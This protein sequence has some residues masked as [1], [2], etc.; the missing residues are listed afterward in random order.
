MHLLPVAA[1]AVAFM[2]APAANADEVIG[3]I[4]A[5]IESTPTVWQTQL[6]EGDDVSRGTNYR[7]FGFVWQVSLLGRPPEDAGDEGDRLVIGFSGID[8][9]IEATEAMIVLFKADGGRSY[10]S[11]EAGDGLVQ[12]SRLE[13]KKGKAFAEGLFAATLCFKEGLFSAP[14]PDDCLEISGT[15][16]SRLPLD[17]S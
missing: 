1:A 9:E 8:G 10:Y 15:F 7:D 11:A 14:D 12:V 17:D 16:T 5:V 3:E 13:L 4:L 2:A 6:P